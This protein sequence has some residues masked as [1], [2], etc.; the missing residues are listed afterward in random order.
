MKTREAVAKRHLPSD[1][2]VIWRGGD[3]KET[4]CLKLSA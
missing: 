3:P 4:G 2:Q 1:L